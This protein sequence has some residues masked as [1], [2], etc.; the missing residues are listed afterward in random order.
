MA[1]E[2]VTA[3]TGSTAPAHPEGFATGTPVKTAAAAA[4]TATASH[5][6]ETVEMEH[7]PASPAAAALARSLPSPSRPP[8]Q[9]PG[10]ATTPLR[11]IRCPSCRT[12]IALFKEGPQRISCPGC[13]KSG[14]Y[15]PKTL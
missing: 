3:P 9:A 8:G 15:R 14:Q 6:V 12:R 11:H 7:A 2:Q 13:G 10:P 1:E 5:A 4:H